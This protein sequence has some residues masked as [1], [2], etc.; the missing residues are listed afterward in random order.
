MTSVKHFHSGMTDAPVL[1]GT[2][3]SLI[4]LLDACLVNGFHPKSADTLTV[5]GGMATASIST[6]H[7]YVVD[8]IV[9]VAGASPATLNGEKRVLSATTNTVMFA[10]D[11]VADQTA[12]GTITLKLA[13]AG[14]A[15]AFAGTNL[16]AYRSANPAGT[17]LYLRVDDTAAQ[18]A[19]VVGYESMADVN[20]GSAPFPTAA[21]VSGG[22]WWPKAS[23]TAATA[24]AWTLVAD[25]RTFW[26]YVNTHPTSAS[27][28]VDGIVF[29]FGDIASLKSGDAY[30]CAIFGHT[31]DIS[32]GTGTQVTNAFLSQTTTTVTAYLARAYT[33]L[34]GSAGAYKR[35]ESFTRQEYASGHASLE[36]PYP[37]GPD[38]ALMLSRL[39]LVEASGNHWRGALRGLHYVPQAL[40]PTTFT[41][42]DKVSGAGALANRKLLAV[43]A[44]GAPAG[45][46]AQAATGFFDVTGPWG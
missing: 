34:G 5:S 29:G 45:T 46:S 7:G 36:V 14:W 28:G 38:N 12:T 25:D 23:T 27:H 31:A 30:G 18:N 19:R 10:A 43:K 24:R 39:V 32:N 8:S 11:G 15:K 6:G 3:G 44:G 41:W 13:P 9:V 21:Q 4:G 2:A 42:L 35:A 26:L 37:N 33:A 40:A 17:R 1:N 22:L 20:T 16:A